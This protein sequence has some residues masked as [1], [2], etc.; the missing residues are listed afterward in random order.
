MR[1]FLLWSWLWMWWKSPRLPRRS[2]KRG[3][4]GRNWSSRRAARTRRGCRASPPK[5]GRRSAHGRAPR[6]FTQRPASSHLPRF[7]HP[8]FPRSRHTEARRHRHCIAEMRSPIPIR[9]F[10]DISSRNS[11]K[12]YQRG[13]VHRPNNSQRL[14]T[15]Q[16]PLPRSETRLLGIAAMLNK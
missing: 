3:D 11:G 5:T 2:W 15:A 1:V 14:Q 12:R 4:S 7:S 9:D 6:R 8:A 10:C 13:V 16:N